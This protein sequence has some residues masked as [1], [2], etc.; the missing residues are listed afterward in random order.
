M[1]GLECSGACLS[2]RLRAYGLSSQ[3]ILLVPVLRFLEL[4]ATGSPAGP[5][6]PWPRTLE[7]LSPPVILYA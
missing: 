1:G 7:M 5:L 3:A 6:L 2:S 4:L